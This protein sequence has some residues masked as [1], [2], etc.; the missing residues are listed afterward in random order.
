M[1]N[2]RRGEIS[3]IL[4]DQPYKLCLTLGALAELEDS[5][6]LDDISAL[7]S[8]FSGGRVRSGDLIKI[9]GAALRAGGTD[10]SD[11][12]AASMRCKGGAPA[13]TSALVD[14]LKETFSP[15]LEDRG[16]HIPHKDKAMPSNAGG[17]GEAPNPGKAGLV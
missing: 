3:L 12:D 5:M 7:A 9:L 6:E 16:Q 4:D 15:E 1:A 14:L 11:S 10:I 8:R 17:Q 2:K 13:L